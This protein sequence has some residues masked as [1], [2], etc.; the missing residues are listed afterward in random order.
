[1]RQRSLR[2]TSLPV[3]LVACLVATA[4]QAVS[5]VGELKD[6]DLENASY[7]L[8]SPDGKQLYVGTFGSRSTDLGSNSVVVFDRDPVSGTLSHQATVPTSYY[9][10]NAI[11]GLA[12]S[13]DGLHLYVIRDNAHDLYGRDPGTGALTPL[14]YHR[15]PEAGSLSNDCHELRFSDDGLFGYCRVN[16]QVQVYARDPVTGLLTYS[17]GFRE[18]AEGGLG[19]FGT[20][21]FSADQSLLYASDMYGRMLTVLSRDAGSGELTLV[22][23]QALP[24]G[25]GSNLKD[26]TLSRDG[27][28]LFAGVSGL[29]D[30]PDSRLMSYTIDPV[31]GTLSHLATYAAADFG[32][33]P[34]IVDITPSADD[35]SL[36]VATNGGLVHLHRDQASGALS[37]VETLSDPAL[38]AGLN[39]VPLA[40][41]DDADQLYFVSKIRDQVVTLQRTPAGGPLTVVGRELGG[42]DLPFAELWQH[43]LF[44]TGDRLVTLS[45]DH[46]T[47]WLCVLE[48]QQDGFEL[49]KTLCVDPEAPPFSLVINEFSRLATGPDGLTFAINASP[50]IATFRLDPDGPSLQLVQRTVGAVLGVYSQIFDADGDQ[51]YASTMNGLTVFAVD[52]DTGTFSEIV[53]YA[54]GVDGFDGVSSSRDLHLV[55][56][57][58]ELLVRGANGW[59]RL[60][61]DPVSGLLQP[62]GALV[63]DRSGGT[64]PYSRYHGLAASPDGN[65]LALFTGTSAEEVVWLERSGDGWQHLYTRTYIPPA[66]DPR[67]ATFS[68]DGQRLA[69][70]S[71]T[72]ASGTPSFITVYQ[73]LADG[74]G[75]RVF[76]QRQYAD[77]LEVTL[78]WARTTDFLYAR[79]DD[80]LFIYES[81]T[82][83]PAPVAIDDNVIVFQGDHLSLDV[84][85][86]DLFATSTL[87][88]VEYSSFFSAVPSGTVHN[89]VQDLGAGVLRFE[90]SHPADYTGDYSFTY[91]LRDS[92]GQPSQARVTIYVWSALAP[93]NTVEV[94]N[95]VTD[96]PGGG[97]ADGAGEVGRPGSAADGAD[98]A[99]ALPS[100]EVCQRA[101]YLLSNCGQDPDYSVQCRDL[102][103]AEAAQLTA[104][105]DTETVVSADGSGTVQ[106]R[107]VPFSNNDHRVTGI[108]GLYTGRVLA[109][110]II[111]GSDRSG[112]RAL[113]DEQHRDWQDNCAVYQCAEYVYEKYYDYENFELGMAALGDDSR[114]IHSLAYNGSLDVAAIAHQ[115]LSQLDGT[116]STQI[117]WPVTARPRNAYFTFRPLPRMFDTAALVEAFIRDLPDGSNDGWYLVGLPNFDWNSA[118]DESGQ[119]LV[120]RVQGVE[121]H[122]H[123]WTFHENASTALASQGHSDDYLLSLAD[124]QE[125]FRK[126]MALRERLVE[127]VYGAQ[128]VMA[129]YYNELVQSDALDEHRRRLEGM[130]EQLSGSSVFG[131]LVTEESVEAVREQRHRL[132][133]ALEDTL[134]V[135]LAL[136]DAL[137]FA[138][139]Q[140]CLET[141]GFTPCDWSPRMLVAEL[142][143]HF[144]EERE[145]DYQRCLLRTGDDFN[146][147]ADSAWLL[148][149][150]QILQFCEDG[151]R[152]TVRLSHIRSVTTLEE[153]FEALQAW[154]EALALPRDP[155]TGLPMVAQSG[156]DS[157]G[158]SAGMFRI[159]YAFDFSWRATDFIDDLCSA[160]V[161]SVGSL[162]VNASAFGVSTADLGFSLF[163]TDLSISTYESAPQVAS[164]DT[165]LSLQVLNIDFGIDPIQGDH[166]INIIEGPVETIE[167][168]PTQSVT[169]LVAGIPLVIR[170]GV[171]GSVGVHIDLYA[172]AEPCSVVDEGLRL[173]V[174]GR[175]EPFARADAFATVSVDAWVAEVGLRTDLNLVKLG[176]PFVTNLQLEMG[177]G[178]AMLTVQSDLDATFGLLD[179]RV[180]AYV[181]ILGED[182]VR[183]IFGWTGPSWTTNLLSFGYVYPLDPLAAALRDSVELPEEPPL[184]VLPRMCTET[185]YDGRQNRDE[186]GVDCGGSC[187]RACPICELGGELLQNGDFEQASGAAGAANLLADGWEALGAASPDLFSV[188]GEIGLLP[189]VADFSH[190]AA[191]SGDR[192]VGASGD[193]G[194][195]LAQQLTTPLTSGQTYRLAAGLRQPS[196]SALDLPGTFTVWLSSSKTLSGAAQ[197]GA[198]APTINPSDAHP[199]E[200]RSL[201][202]AA[203]ADAESKSWLLVE[204]SGPYLGIDRLELHAAEVCQ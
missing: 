135:D 34:Y 10:V 72:S 90:L 163:S 172:R 192:F 31:S 4:A 11:H 143:N 68:D 62:L 168:M 3:L 108:D 70:L 13:P 199:W 191:Y 118:L 63:D 175:F 5:A 15:F 150:E 24:A 189:S 131:E 77:K 19:R 174:R 85:A 9:L 98:Q 99:C 193:G 109:N 171:N 36:Y 7:G 114:A 133:Q 203:P 101:D 23:T 82:P 156:S 181:E 86:N 59:M 159:D 56:G 106:A 139:Q 26:F 196:A 104:G 153:Y 79:A 35:S 37:P 116:P 21:H 100:L 111:A 65:S 148:E 154:V 18:G 41:P 92:V 61:R 194:E 96:D 155:E 32:V 173:D 144:S 137:L 57:E 51:L 161:S 186:T 200:A 195:V 145:A 88:H 184:Q 45:R 115:T 107:V 103:A 124:A 12:I 93:D 158:E 54:E 43:A 40:A 33:L 30:V 75:F 102:L 49:G 128:L 1:M 138:E 151:Q 64:D 129:Y 134:Q 164:I 28:Y 183:R 202:F 87:V 179:G 73:R 46:D 188:S 67:A 176:L 122:L 178:E 141:T 182:Y 8:L 55:R 50:G 27:K 125:Q 169:V 201:I 80:G 2:L 74:S 29:S 162:D 42:G 17:S 146:R 84:L 44:P 160:R 136:H 20:V 105:L 170:G 120:D 198:V 132:A 121:G 185:C 58:T 66:Y 152:C 47:D 197:L 22:Q 117:R 166:E 16:Y 71:E 157:G 95:T 187:R 52:P 147:A 110:R 204:P 126:L 91:T 53:S 119:V 167:L 142:S 127:E 149:Q 14:S 60:G 78:D 83:P 97:P 81:V 69:V 177:G 123:N 190:A 48:R 165:A 94:V 38:L 89:V 112:A 140:G 76:E 39:T 113:L 25:G 130:Q 180:S 6:G